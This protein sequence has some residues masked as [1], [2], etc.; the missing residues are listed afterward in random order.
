MALKQILIFDLDGTL[1]EFPRQ[2]LFAATQAVRV[3]LGLAEAAEADLQYHFSRFDFFSAFEASSRK[4]TS[5]RLAAEL[6][7]RGH[8]PLKPFADTEEVLQ[9]LLHRGHRLAIATA[10]I[11]PREQLRSE[12]EACRLAGYFSFL[13]P[14]EATSAEW[15]DKSQQIEEICRHYGVQ[16]SEAA[17]IGDIPADVLSAKKSGIAQTFA[18]TTGGILPEVLQATEP[19]AVLTSLSELLRF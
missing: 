9:T 17:F 13:A 8:P 19:E 1:V 2:H 15:T 4:E 12:L 3:Q 10:R 16:A 6:E 14:R 5:E 7:R 18:M 11:V